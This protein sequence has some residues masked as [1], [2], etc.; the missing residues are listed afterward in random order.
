MAT[1]SIRC[2]M[3]VHNAYKNHM[4]RQHAPTLLRTENGINMSRPNDSHSLPLSKHIT[5]TTR[6]KQQ[7]SSTF[8]RLDTLCYST[9][10]MLHC[11]L[12][13][14]ISPSNNSHLAPRILLLPMQMLVP[15]FFQIVRKTYQRR[16]TFDVSR[17]LRTYP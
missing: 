4:G 1:Q 5:R 12:S 15:V 14:Q 16:P 17:T 7:L 11:D 9:S 6:K 10:S 8:V 13:P 2:G 3:T